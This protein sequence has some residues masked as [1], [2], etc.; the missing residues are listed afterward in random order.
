M[1]ETERD[2]HEAEERLHDIFEPDVLLPV[3][4]FA[5]LKRKKYKSGEHRL[6]VAIMQDAVE[7]FQK[8]IHARDSKRRQLYLDAETWIGEDD[9]L[10]VFSFNNVCALL[11]IDV[12]YVRKGLLDWRDMQRS[13]RRGR[14]YA[15]AKRPVRREQVRIKAPQPLAPL[16]EA[17]PTQGQA[18]LYAAAEG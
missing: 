3:Q 12:E 13:R 1:A 17:S 10:N 15:R 2:R 6:V 7:C 8:H 5:Q 16:S 4:Y 18:E 9:D 11:S 14:L